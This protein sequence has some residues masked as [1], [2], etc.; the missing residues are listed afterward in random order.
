MVVYAETVTVIIVFRKGAKD[1]DWLNFSETMPYQTLLHNIRLR[2]EAR[3]VSSYFVL[4]KD[5]V[6]AKVETI[7]VHDFQNL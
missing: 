2:F 5:N 6:S 1:E 7:F 4:S 3:K